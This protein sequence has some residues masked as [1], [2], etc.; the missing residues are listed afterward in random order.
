MC[1]PGCLYVA[2]AA[3]AA[4]ARHLG[5]GCCCGLVVT[6][7]LWLRVAAPPARCVPQVRASGEVGWGPRHD[8]S[9]Y[10]PHGSHLVL[11]HSRVSGGATGRT[12]CSC[13]AA[14][15]LVFRGCVAPPRHQDALGALWGVTALQGPEKQVQTHKLKILLVG[16]VKYKKE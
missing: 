15:P 2:A 3:A 11:R 7:C 14:A 9:P 8:L 12:W 6:T 4:D 1:R 5:P 16:M 10:S 13:G